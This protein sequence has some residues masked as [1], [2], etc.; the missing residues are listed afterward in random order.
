MDKG[1]FALGYKDRDVEVVFLE[2]GECLI[3]ACDSCGAIG[4][5]P[6]DAVKAPAGLTGRLTARVALMEV[7]AVG[8]LPRVMAVTIANEPVPTGEEILAGIKEEL[9]M[10]GLESLPMAVSTEKNMPTRQTGL[11][12]T[13]AGTCAE[14][15]LR[16]ACT[17]P[18]DLLYCLGI[19]KVGEEVLREGLMSLVSG[20]HVRR[21]LTCRGV[22]DVLPVGSGGIRREGE[23]LARSVGAAVQWEE[24]K[25][26]GLGQ[27]AGPSTCVLFTLEA[28]KGG[29]RQPDLPDWGEIQLIKVG[30][31]V[32][33]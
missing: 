27:S 26:P 5:L 12:V 28:G 19:P 3:T 4:A 33:Q 6:L 9:G 16:V 13:V 11:G 24:R 1:A 22:H 20:R 30:S 15:E 2:H 31:I 25:G 32:R 23:R 21:L 14:D 29:D 8:G 18:G 10:L 17:R 7:L